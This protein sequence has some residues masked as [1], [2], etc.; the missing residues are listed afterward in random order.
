[1]YIEPDIIVVTMNKQNGWLHFFAETKLKNTRK[2]K[3]KMSNENISETQWNTVT[4][5]E[6]TTF[7]IFIEYS[8]NFSV[9][10]PFFL[11]FLVIA[12]VFVVLVGQTVISVREVFD[13]NQW[14]WISNHIEM[15]YFLRAHYFYCNY[16]DYE[17]GNWN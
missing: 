6:I 11:L 1:M 17:N 14:N 2:K 3:L 7:I 16:P 4:W 9:F 12:S 10:L 5:I 8:V 13:I 15:D